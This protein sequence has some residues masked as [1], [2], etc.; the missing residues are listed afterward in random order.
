MR[1]DDVGARTLS[2][3]DRFRDI[4]F[5]YRPIEE[6]MLTRRRRNLHRYRLPFVYSSQQDLLLEL[7]SLMRSLQRTKPSARRSDQILRDLLMYQISYHTR[8][9]RC[10]TLRYLEVNHLTNPFQDIQWLL[11][12]GWSEYVGSTD[13]FRKRLEEFM[14]SMDEVRNQMRDGAFLGVTLPRRSTIF[15]ISNLR[16]LQEW[17]RNYRP[18]HEL[19]VTVRR[20]AQQV[21]TYLTGWINYL[22]DEYL[23][24]AQ[25]HIGLLHLPGGR[26]S[27]REILKLHTG[28]DD[29]EPEVV[30][31]LG[32]RILREL[33]SKMQALPSSA[34]SAGTTQHEVFL[35]FE[36]ARRAFDQTHRA[37]RSSLQGLFPEPPTYQSAP[38]VPVPEEEEAGAIS[39]AYD[40]RV[41]LSAATLTPAETLGLSLHEHWPGHHLQTEWANYMAQQVHEALLLMY[42]N[43]V[44]EGWG[45]YSEGFLPADAGVEARRAQLQAEMFRAARLVVDVGIHWHGWGEA[46]AVQF[47]RRTL[48]WMPE[49]EVQNEVL[50]YA[51]LPGQALSYTIGKRCLQNLSRRFGGTPAAFHEYVL[52]HS[53]LPC[54]LLDR[55]MPRKRVGI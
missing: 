1:R 21:A 38:I 39:A 53:F 19:R 22:Q 28:R 50:R 35:D 45:L 34:A 27:Y 18:S 52:R 46:K 48:P 37:L 49:L 31:R 8:Y 55:Y 43:D 29:L 12:S 7:Q 33:R 25:E 13:R 40:G 24:R 44:V 2:L 14:R 3:L 32:R 54:V 42:S 23:P 20:L 6:T 41:L 17:F 30:E 5:R 9:I 26:E 36:S 15:L 51:V 47:M 10:T 16:R 4:M 11:S